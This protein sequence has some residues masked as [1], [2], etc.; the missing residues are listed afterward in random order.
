MILT[1]H[2]A[3]TLTVIALT[4]AGPHLNHTHTDTDCYPRAGDGACTGGTDP[5]IAPDAP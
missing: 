3:P 2:L 5:P 1:R 4:I